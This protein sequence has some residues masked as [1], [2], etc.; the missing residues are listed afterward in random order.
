MSL[1]R[2]SAVYSTYFYKKTIEFLE[3]LFAA[4][5][6]S[7]A[8]ESGLYWIEK[9]PIRTGRLK[10]VFLCLGMELK[11]LVD[12]IAEHIRGL[13]LA[14]K[15]WSLDPETSFL[16][17]TDTFSSNTLAFW[18]KDGHLG[19]V[20][21]TKGRSRLR[22]EL[23]VI[24][25]SVLVAFGV[26]VALLPSLMEITGTDFNS[27]YGYILGNILILVVIFVTFPPFYWAFNRKIVKSAE[28]IL[29]L[30]RDTAE[31]KGACKFRFGG[32]SPFK[33][34]PRVSYRNMYVFF[35]ALGKEEEP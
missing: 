32:R 25:V 14:V 9:T 23:P 17:V 8:N 31:T 10:Y 35:K 11:S 30:V 16:H 6:T 1:K 13:G 33:F 3:T 12:E 21:V 26:V 27:P 22:A 5:G 34:P 7:T 19:I 29:P 20:I 15:N 18:R 4:Y 28:S 2:S 24:L